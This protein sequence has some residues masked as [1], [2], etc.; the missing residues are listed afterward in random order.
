[1]IEASVLAFAGIIVT[2]VLTAF[3]VLIGHQARRISDVEGRVETAKR[4]NHRL[5]LAYRTLLD[6][7]YRYR[8]P[9]APD[10]DRLEEESSAD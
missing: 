9:G 7:Y 5:W 8:T 6:L 3:G 2:G 1:M 4:Q 10:P